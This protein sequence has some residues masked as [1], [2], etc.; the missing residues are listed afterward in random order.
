[1]DG[2]GALAR[3]LRSGLG[4]LRP[5]TIGEV[6]LRFVEEEAVGAADLEQAAPRFGRAGPPVI[7]SRCIARSR[8]R[9]VRRSVGS[10]AR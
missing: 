1:M 3:Q 9:K 6:R 4:V 10:C 8:R 5:G 2:V 7:P